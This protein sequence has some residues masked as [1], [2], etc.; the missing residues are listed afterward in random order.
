MQRDENNG[1]AC[2][3]HE[4]TGSTAFVGG[5]WVSVP[6][7][8]CAALRRT[9]W[10]TLE[11]PCQTMDCPCERAALDAIGRAVAI[12]TLRVTQTSESMARWRDMMVMSHKH[13]I[14]GESVEKGRSYR[15]DPFQPTK[16][17]TILQ[18]Q[19]P[20]FHAA[21]QKIHSQSSPSWTGDFAPGPL[22]KQTIF[23]TNPK[24]AHGER[25]ENHDERYASGVG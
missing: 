6:H 19:W 15:R 25:R 1:S 11:A 18:P 7:L 24:A 20:P 4:T 2:E 23:N 10:Q 9:L 3:S 17:P 16:V 8:A 5:V 12:P 13:D 21:G 14:I 22:T